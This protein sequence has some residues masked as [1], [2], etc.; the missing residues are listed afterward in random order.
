MAAGAERNHA[1]RAS[2]A[3]SSFDANLA[4]MRRR[5]CPIVG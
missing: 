3:A 2:N 1:L 4:V 5:P